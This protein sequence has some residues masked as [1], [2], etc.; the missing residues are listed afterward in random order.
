MENCG[1]TLFGRILEKSKY[2]HGPSHLYLSPLKYEFYNGK[3]KKNCKTKAHGSHYKKSNYLDLR[4][5]KSPEH[6]DG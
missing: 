1:M 2:S 3:K 6:Q 5:N 4:Q